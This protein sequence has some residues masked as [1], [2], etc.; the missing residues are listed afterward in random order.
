VQFAFDEAYDTVLTTLA[1]RDRSDNAI[2]AM[3]AE[4]TWAPFV[5]RLGC[6]RGVGTLTGFGLAV[7]IV[8]PLSCG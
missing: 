5:A 7:D 3:A 1:R 2:L 8:S 4:P 6:L